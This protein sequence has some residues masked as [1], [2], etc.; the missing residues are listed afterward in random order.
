MMNNQPLS[1]EQEAFARKTFIEP[2]LFAERVL[3]ANLWEKEVEI[4]E[5]IRKKSPDCD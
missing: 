5:S 4:L 2:V 3:G 1:D